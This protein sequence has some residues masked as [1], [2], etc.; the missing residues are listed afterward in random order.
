MSYTDKERSMTIFSRLR[1]GSLLITVL[2]AIVALGFAVGMVIDLYFRDTI[3]HEE[4]S[5]EERLIGIRRATHRY[6]MMHDWSELMNEDSTEVTFDSTLGEGI[7]GYS[8]PAAPNAWKVNTIYYT[9]ANLTEAENLPRYIVLGSLSDPCT[10]SPGANT[11]WGR[12]QTA[13]GAVAGPPPAANTLNDYKVPP[14]AVKFLR[15]LIR[16]GYLNMSEEDVLQP[17]VAIYPH[18]DAVW[19]GAPRIFNPEM[20]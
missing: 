13:L 9:I 16:T 17:W 14:N 4:S 2:M 10:Y 12:A 15:R 7:A 18:S 5:Y 3:S 1:R 8:A 19:L 20:H 6:L 11:P